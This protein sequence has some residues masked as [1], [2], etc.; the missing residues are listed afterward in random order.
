[1]PQVFARP[2]D[3]ERFATQLQQFNN[4]LESRFA[5]LQSQFNQL[6]D[7]WRDQEHARFAQEFQQ[8]ARMLAQ[9]K[10]S[11]EQQIP[12]LKTKAKHLRDYSG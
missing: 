12:F 4:D 8:T 7:T 1:M 9:F 6:G 3:I 5:V 11:S 10:R 2:E